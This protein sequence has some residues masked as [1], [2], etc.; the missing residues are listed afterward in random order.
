MLCKL[1]P[2]VR[3]S[4]L[5]GVGPVLDVSREVGA[6][7]LD[8]EAGVGLQS[9][10]GSDAVKKARVD[11]PVNV[12]PVG[13]GLLGLVDRVDRDGV[14]V[15]LPDRVG[16]VPRLDGFGG[17]VGLLQILGGEMFQ[18]EVGVWKKACLS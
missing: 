8:V 12:H 9:S 1:T 13:P 16:V 14:V 7:G 5:D 11:E 18:L 2:E 15:L 3:G 6:E 10:L 17:A 4:A